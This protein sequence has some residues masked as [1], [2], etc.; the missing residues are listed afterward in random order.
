M[1]GL[2]WFVAETAAILLVASGVGKVRYP[3]GAARAL[4]AAG[5]PHGF[6]V[7]RAF[8]LIEIAVGLLAAVGPIRVTFIAVAS[9]YAF[10]AGMLLYFL[11]GR[12]QLTSCGCA[13]KVDVPPSWLH[14]VLNVAAAATAA[15][16]AFYGRTL[17]TVVAETRGYA[18][19]FALTLP[20]SAYL[21]YL[22]VLRSHGPLTIPRPSQAR[23]DDLAFRL[24]TQRGGERV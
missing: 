2:L 3:L 5:L 13:G 24:Y 7:V 21:I 23:T 15:L 6:R 1:T 14:A 19:T 20:I 9:A 4:L 12:V 8:G 16:A 18:V 11:V 22:V 17:P 10:F